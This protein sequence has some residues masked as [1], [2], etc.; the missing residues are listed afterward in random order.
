MAVNI[1]QN[2]AKSIPKGDDQIVRVDMDVL[3]IGGR[4]SAM[5]AQEKSGALGLSH[6][7]NAGSTVGK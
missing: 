1:F 4:K 6:V 2:Q 5:P 3:E 7:P